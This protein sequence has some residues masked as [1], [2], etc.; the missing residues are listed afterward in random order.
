MVMVVIFTVKKNPSFVATEGWRRVRN[1]MTRRMEKTAMGA[2]I[3][4]KLQSVAT[5]PFVLVWVSS[6]MTEISTMGTVA[7][8]HVNVNQVVGMAKQSQNL[9]KSVMTRRMEKTVMN[10]PTAAKP[11]SV[12]IRFFVYL[13][14]KSAMTEMLRVEMAAPRIVRKRLCQDVVIKK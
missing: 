13:K 10:A 6:V 14:K 9:E 8:V 4:A 2:P 3:A 1:V 5:R 11:Q 7:P 12:V